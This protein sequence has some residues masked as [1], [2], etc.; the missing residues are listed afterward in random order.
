MGVL[1]AAH[2]ARYR[3]AEPSRCKHEFFNCY[4]AFWTQRRQTIDTLQR[5][6]KMTPS[7]GA[8]AR[9]RRHSIGIEHHSRIRSTSLN[10]ISS[11]VRSYSLVVRGDS[12]PPPSAWGASS[13]PSFS[14]SAATFR[15]TA[16]RRWSES[17][18]FQYGQWRYQRV[19]VRPRTY[20]ESPSQR[21]GRR[22]TR[23]AAHDSRVGAGK[24]L[25]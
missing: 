9:P 23:R 14:V 4:G 7:G 5:R 12:C 17:G 3:V 13:C 8:L 1:H 18:R 11:F 15:L 20:G 6:K 16:E 10:V 19:E 25:Y 22:V 21:G 24:R 2:V